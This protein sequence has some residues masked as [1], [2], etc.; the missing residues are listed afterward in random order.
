MLLVG[1]WGGG[2]GRGRLL[3]AEAALQ[4]LAGAEGALGIGSGHQ[5]SLG[6]RTTWKR[7]S[8]MRVAG[9]QASAV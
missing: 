1:L 3:L 6:E 9:I 7:W 5:D 8:R 4:R 2:G